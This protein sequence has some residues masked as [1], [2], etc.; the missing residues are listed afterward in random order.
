MNI[1]VVGTGYVGLVTGACLAESGNNV[2]CVDIDEVKIRSLSQG[3]VPFFEPGLDDLVQK[4][5]KEGRLH[6]TTNLSEAVQ[7]SFIIFIAVGTPPDGDGS[8]DVS[9][10]LDVARSIGKSMNDYKIVVTKSTVPVG[11]TE[12]VREVIRSVTDIEFD[13]ASN[14]E[15]LKEGAAVEDFMKPDR[16]VIGADKPS[17]AGIL[18]EL[19]SPFMRSGDRA[20]IASIRS[21]ELAKY[22]ANAMLATR[23]SFMNEMANLCELVGADVSEIRLIIGA[24]SRIGRS[25]LFPGIGYGGSCF[26]KDVKALIKTAERM[27]YELKICKAT[28]EVNTNQREIFWNKIKTFFKGNLSGKRIG[29][30]GLSFKP[31]TDDI[32]EAPSLFIVNRLISHG[33]EVVVHDPVAMGRAREYFGDKVRYA[34]SNYDACVD[35]HALVIHTEWNEYRQPDFDTLKKIMR[36]PVIFDGRNLYDPKK[37]ERLGFK[38]FGVGVSN[39]IPAD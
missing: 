19:Y 11:T 20:I 29:V 35:A 32:R 27:G 6:F 16:V 18:K 10:V 15:F 23:I 24:D 9:A 30:W 37:L 25:F 38:Y 33:A 22:A 1:C 2:I 4:N 17:V 5:L 7:R 36:I 8:A 21:A 14:P 26:P 39:S 13:V 12:K 34:E 28:D 31:K 3:I